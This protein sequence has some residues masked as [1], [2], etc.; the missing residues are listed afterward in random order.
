MMSRLYAYYIPIWVVVTIAMLLYILV[1]LK[2]HRNNVLLSSLQSKP[3]SNA[4]SRTFE[5]SVSYSLAPDRWSIPGEAPNPTAPLSSTSVTITAPPSPS[6]PRFPLLRKLFTTTP[7]LSPSDRST[8]AYSRVAFLFFASNLITWVPASINRVYSIY[9]PDTPSFVLNVAA[10]IVL[11]LQ[12]LW[13]C[14]IYLIVNRP[15]LLGIFAEWKGKA[16]RGRSEVGVQG[17]E[18]SEDVE[19]E[20]LKDGAR[21]AE[22][23]ESDDDGKL[24]GLREALEYTR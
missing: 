10:A 6:L 21:N 4:S 11:P 1:G 17:E 18:R 8:T 3:L 12:G 7:Y 22:S 24:Q 19:M 5:H 16:M 14:A 13:N 20:G 15:L 9:H 23:V 2:I